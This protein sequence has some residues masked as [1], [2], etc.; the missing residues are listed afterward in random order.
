M[1]TGVNSPKGDL[2]V[3][4]K[5]GECQRVGYCRR[6]KEKRS[7]FFFLFAYYWVISKYL[8]YNGWCPRKVI[9]SLEFWASLFYFC[10]EMKSFHLFY[11]FLFKCKLNHHSSACLPK[12]DITKP[13]HSF[14]MNVN[15][16]QNLQHSSAQ[17]ALW[18][19]IL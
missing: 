12:I 11:P 6:Q 10:A 3:T 19:I 5:V 4:N 18:N 2:R 9:N 15:S 7:H 13:Q 14:L 16:V 8:Q 1:N 17:V